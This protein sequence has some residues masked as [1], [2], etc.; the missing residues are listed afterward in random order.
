M[1]ELIWHDRTK[2]LPDYDKPIYIKDAKAGDAH[3]LKT[4]RTKN[5]ARR[6]DGDDV[7]YRYRKCWTHWA[8][9]V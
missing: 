7:I 1:T 5:T 4:L 2:E 3:V 9:V 6:R 8:Y